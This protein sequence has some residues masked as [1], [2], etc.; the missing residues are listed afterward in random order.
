MDLCVFTEAVYNWLMEFI[1][2]IS[3]QIYFLSEGAMGFHCNWGEE[4]KMPFICL[5]KTIE[6]ILNNF[7]VEEYPAV[8]YIARAV[9]VNFGTV[10]SF[11]DEL[12]DGINPI[13]LAAGDFPI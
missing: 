10:L 9:V 2:H 4:G 3:E 6:L 5:K 7:L 13:V 1:M 8:G 12:L 11:P